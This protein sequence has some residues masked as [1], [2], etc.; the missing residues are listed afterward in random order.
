MFLVEV[1]NFKLV[2]NWFVRNKLQIL[3]HL[4][5]SFLT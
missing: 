4:D 5:F 1:A 2:S 3:T